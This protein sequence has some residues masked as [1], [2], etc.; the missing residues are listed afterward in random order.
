[1]RRTDDFTVKQKLLVVDTKVKDQSVV[2][3]KVHLHPYILQVHFTM[4]IFSRYWLERRTENQ[5]RI[6]VREQEGKSKVKDDGDRNRSDERKEEVIARKYSYQHLSLFF[7]FP[8]S[9]LMR[10]GRER[11]TIQ[12]TFP[13]STRAVVI[14]IRQI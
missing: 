2:F 9:M 1:M 11:V 13:P 5:K 6:K 4:D 8:V 14:I 7:W 3:M 10:I 12:L